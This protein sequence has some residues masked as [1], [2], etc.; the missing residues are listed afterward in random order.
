MLDARGSRRSEYDKQ[1][2][3]LEFFQVLFVYSKR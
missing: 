1:K 3:H 2:Q